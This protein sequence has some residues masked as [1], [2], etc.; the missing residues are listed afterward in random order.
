MGYSLPLYLRHEPTT[1]L[2]TIACHNAFGGTLP[3][4]VVAYRDPECRDVAA[5]WPWHFHFS[6]PRPG[7]KRVKLHCFTWQPIWL[8]DQEG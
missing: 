2:R 4:D 7:M 8:P 1:D 3:K 6:K 5:R